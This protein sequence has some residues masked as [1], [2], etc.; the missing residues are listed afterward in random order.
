MDYAFCSFSF[1]RL[2]AEGKQ[3]IFRHIS[4]CSNLGACR[5][6]PGTRISP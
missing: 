1:H 2:L 6:A 5:L 3:D 4:D